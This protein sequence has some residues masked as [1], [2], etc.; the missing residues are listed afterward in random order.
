MDVN[1]RIGPVPTS[2]ATTWLGTAEKTVHILRRSDELAVPWDVLEAFESF[3]AEWREHAERNPVT[4]DWTRA[5]DERVIRR[6]G[7]HWAR[8]VSVTRSGRA[9]ELSTAPAEGAAFYEAIAT[10][11]AE[12]LAEGTN[13][14]VA[15]LFTEAIPRFDAPRPTTPSA[16]AT[17]VLVVDDDQDMRM[18]LRVWLEGDPRLEV[19]GEAGDWHEA[20]QVAQATRPEVVVLDVEMQG[21]SGL[22]ALPLIQKASPDCSVVVFSGGGRHAEALRAGASSYIS[23]GSP[24][25][26]VVSAVLDAST[27]HSP[28]R[29]RT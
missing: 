14:A 6:I 15:G 8:I 16:P 17:R 28:P 5:V 1:V 3:L 19:V 9:A 18:V 26:Q 21:T 23:K 10:G 24:L 22:E 29:D 11:V 7:L 20:I 2:S 4:F 27:T 25:E 13:T 12:A